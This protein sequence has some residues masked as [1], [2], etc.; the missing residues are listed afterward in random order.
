VNGNIYLSGTLARRIRFETPSSGI[1]SRKPGLMFQRPDGTELGRIEYVDTAN[2]TNYIRIGIGNTGSNDL[3]VRDN[4]VS[5]GSLLPLAKLHIQGE[6][7]DDEL[8]IKGAIGETGTI[9]FYKQPA[10]SSAEKKGFVQL[11]GDDLRLGTN[12]GNVNGSFVVR[13]NGADRMYVDESGN[14]SIA[15]AQTAVGYKLNVGGKI[16]CEEMKVQ[17]MGAWPDYVF[18]EDYP[19]RKLEN[20]DVFIKNNKHLPGIPSANEVAEQGISVGQMQKQMMEKIEELTLYVIQLNRE[21]NELKSKN[22]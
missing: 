12:S 6:P 18:R 16:I 20:L 21:L 14:V 4:K 2:F 15:T 7:G 10:G 22:R 13:T 3:I 5:V 8:S 9:Q 1:A 19:L 17:L 11:D